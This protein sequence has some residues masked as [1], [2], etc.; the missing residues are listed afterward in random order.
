ML[1]DLLIWRQAQGGS[2]IAVVNTAGDDRA[3][4]TFDDGSRHLI[5]ILSEGGSDDAA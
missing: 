4:V 5:I 3:V 2:G 1:H